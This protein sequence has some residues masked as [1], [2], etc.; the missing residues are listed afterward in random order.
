MKVCERVLPRASLLATSPRDDDL[1]K[2]A[3]LCGWLILRPSFP[4]DDDPEKVVT[5]CGQKKTPLVLK[6]SW[7]EFVPLDDDLEKAE[8]VYELVSFP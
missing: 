5:V 8:N 2:V 4:L 7:S 6:V 1:E 3:K